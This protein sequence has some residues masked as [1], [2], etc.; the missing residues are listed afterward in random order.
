MGTRASIARFLNFYPQFRLDDLQTMGPN[1]FRYL[2]GGMLD[3][4]NPDQTDPSEVRMRRRV[5]E[6]HRAATARMWQR[7]R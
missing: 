3:V 6:A 2:Y 5:M 4:L 7:R 1:T